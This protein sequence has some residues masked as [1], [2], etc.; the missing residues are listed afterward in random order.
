[1]KANTWGSTQASHNMYGELLIEIGIIGFA[2]FIRFISQIYRRFSQNKNIIKELVDSKENEFYRNL[3]KALIAVF[4]MY[5]VYSINYWG[6][7]QYY[8]Y[9]FAG[10]AVAFGRLLKQQYDLEQGGGEESVLPATPRYPLA[11]RINR[12]Y[13]RV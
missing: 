7:S 1:V 10:L 13:A 2:L 6:L 5:A 9:L 3:N 11:G 8:W 12:R 4:W